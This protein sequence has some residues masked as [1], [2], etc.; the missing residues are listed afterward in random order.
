MPIDIVFSGGGTR[1]VAL[2]G[3]MEVLEKRLPIVR[4]VVGTSAG[5]IAAVFGAAGYL[6]RDYLKLVPMKPGD[7]FM[8]SSF[9]GPPSADEVR[10]A[11]RK[12]DS[13]TRKL[14]RT[15][16]DGGTDKMLEKMA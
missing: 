4:R 1:G 15:A 3:A 9:F 13:E 7:P 5:A 2:G 6:T 8:F 12:K 14:L 10:E 11:V 16:F